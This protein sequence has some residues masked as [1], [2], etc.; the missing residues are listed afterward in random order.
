MRKLKHT[1]GQRATLSGSCVLAFLKR[2]SQLADRIVTQRL[3]PRHREPTRYS[4]LLTGL[5]QAQAAP[6]P[7][8]K[9]GV[10]CSGL[11]LTPQS[12]G[13]TERRLDAIIKEDTWAGPSKLLLILSS[14]VC[15]MTPHPQQRSAP[16][17]GGGLSRR[18]MGRSWLVLGA[19]GALNKL[20]PQNWLS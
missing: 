19:R 11:D 13:D 5:E 2:R 9:K 6:S 15:K 17:R 4:N 8:R 12:C 16:G 14:S 20:P 1:L 7:R 10:C 18:L 3:C